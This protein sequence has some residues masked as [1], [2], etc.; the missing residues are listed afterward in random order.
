MLLTN[1]INY[2]I[3]EEL[4]MYQNTLVYVSVVDKKA[5]RAPSHV[6]V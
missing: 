4:V 6:G 3:F 1:Q 2:W 5:K